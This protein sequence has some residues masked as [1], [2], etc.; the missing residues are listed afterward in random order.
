MKE[1]LRIFV[2]HLHWP[3]KHQVKC[4][5][6]FPVNEDYPFH[7]HSAL[8]Q[9]ERPKALSE[10]FSS[11]AFDMLF[12]LISNVFKYLYTLLSV[13]CTIRTMTYVVFCKGPLFVWL[14][15]DGLLQEL[16]YLIHLSNIVLLSVDDGIY[17]LLY[18]I[19]FL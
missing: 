5:W 18:R 15:L 19:I 12:V 11:F 16:P 13:V 2:L 4:K 7:S 8:L 6:L 14:F 9:T 3:Y 17:C 1:K 10:S